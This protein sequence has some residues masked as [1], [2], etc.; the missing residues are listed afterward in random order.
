MGKLGLEIENSKELA[1]GIRI[2]I[3][4][5]L[6]EFPREPSHGAYGGHGNERVGTWS[7][8]HIW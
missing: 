3:R 1:T 6:P 7:R 5:N 2:S 4:S 8:D